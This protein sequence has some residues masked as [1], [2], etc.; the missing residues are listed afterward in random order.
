MVRTSSVASVKT[1]SQK[2]LGLVPTFLGVTGKKPSRGT[3]LPPL[4]L[5]RINFYTSLAS[6]K[7]LYFRHM[8]HCDTKLDKKVTLLS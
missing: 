4:I 7:Y 5:D 2:F 6:Y 8:F 1:R 3:F